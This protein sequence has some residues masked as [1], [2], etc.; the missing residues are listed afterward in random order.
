MSPVKPLA[1]NNASLNILKDPKPFLFS[2]LFLPLF[3]SPALLFF[4]PAFLH[5]SCSLYW[6]WQSIPS[7]FEF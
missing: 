7:L 2:S 5:C 4:H 3:L 1:T 6:Q